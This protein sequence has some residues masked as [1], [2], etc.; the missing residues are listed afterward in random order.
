[1]ITK[2]DSYIKVNETRRSR[3]EMRKQKEIKATLH[4]NGRAVCEV[5]TVCGQEDQN[6]EGTAISMLWLKFQQDV[7]KDI[8]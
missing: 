4:V 5:L 6:P 2:G 7:G 1:M 8:R 3:D